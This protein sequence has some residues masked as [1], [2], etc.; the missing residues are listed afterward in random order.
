MK[1]ITMTIPDM[2]H[3]HCQAR[4]SNAVKTVDGVQIEQVTAG[5]IALALSTDAQLDQ[6]RQ[7]IEKA[8][9]SVTPDADIEP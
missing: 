3:M 9:Y 6:V 8:G 4:V 7:A 2:Q 1:R 5:K